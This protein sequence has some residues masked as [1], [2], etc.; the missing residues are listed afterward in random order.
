M[1]IKYRV[2]RVMSDGECCIAGE[3]DGKSHG[4]TAY[5]KD[6]HAHTKDCA[7]A[8]L[9]AQVFEKV[10]AVPETLDADGNVI[11]PAVPA[12]MESPRD[13]IKAWFG[14]VKPAPTNVSMPQKDVERVV[15][16]KKKTVKED[17]RDLL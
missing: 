3:E 1:A 10:A 6:S 12:V 17:D 11:S 7:Q 15:D 14:A 16:G 8:I 4:E 2:I 13:R 9:D 5:C